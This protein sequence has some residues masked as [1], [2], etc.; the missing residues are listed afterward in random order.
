MLTYWP[1]KI[2]LICKQVMRAGDESNIEDDY[3]NERHVLSSLRCLKHPSI[4]KLVTAYSKGDTYNFL[5]PVADGDLKH[6]LSLEERPLLLES[7]QA[8]FDALWS[9]SSAVES[10]HS[11]F[12]KDFN[13]RQVG[14]HYDIKPGNILYQSE[15]FLLSDFGLSRLRNDSEG[16]RS[17]Y[18]GV[19]GSYIAPECE[20]ASDGFERAKIGRSSDVWSFGCFLFEMLAYLHGGP[21]A[22][23]RLYTGRRVKLGPHWA[24]YFHAGD[25]INPAVTAFLQSF[26]TRNPKNEGFHSLSNIIKAALQIEPEKR[27]NASLMTLSLFHLAQR[28]KFQAICSLLDNRSYLRD[29]ELEMEYQRLK[30]WAEAVGLA[31][32]WHEM[33]NTVWLATPRNH[34]ELERVQDGLKKCHE[35]M[36]SVKDAVENNRPFTNHRYYHLQRSQD[37][38]WDMQPAPVRKSMMSRLEDM[39]LNADDPA[40]LPDSET[41]Q[42]KSQS[43][44]DTEVP[45]SPYRRIILL[46][47]MKQI[48]AAITH[49]K[50]PEKDLM[51]DKGLLSKPFAPYHC[52]F[53]ASLE[54]VERKVLIEKMVYQESWYPR[55]DELLQ[56]VKA[57]TS[58]RDNIQDVIP[59]LESRGYY[60]EP[61][62]HFFG[63]VYELPSLAKD[64]LPMSLHDLIQDTQ[65]RLHQ[66][67]LTMKFDL[68]SKLVDCVLS[69]H[70]AGWLHKNICSFNL[71]CFPGVFSAKAASITDPYMI[72]FNYSRL[73]DK[74]AFTEGPGYELALREYQHPEYLRSSL[75]EYSRHEDS[76]IRYRQ[77]FEYYSVGLVLLEIGLWKPLSRITK[78]L[79]GSPDEMLKRLLKDYIPVVKTHMG[80]FYGE[81][82]KVCLTS[83]SQGIEEPYEA[84][85]VFESGVVSPIR[86]RRI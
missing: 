43:K 33:P 67:S 51:L 41:I 75:G 42:H 1:P 3:N 13:V 11:Y 55:I 62:Q 6:F 86:E 53:V 30:I 80:D 14:C 15:R 12:S 32:E 64:T 82:V 72:G 26:D 81:A 22:V 65:N 39:V 38:L 27:S 66:P 18:K 10:M 69:F 8:I 31:F 74:T 21:K 70:K 2:G 34:E 46:A 61:S 54:G 20:P 56:R 7:D 44:I 40:S 73:N 28:N 17:L 68:A 71:M 58:F 85:R 16:S 52:H 9:L 37:D 25:S 47:M 60:H 83:Y 49:Q 45:R 76:Q 48:G 57:I 29:F 36:K 78:P 84:R 5:F 50:R 63:I 23:S 59:I 77:E 35:E 79:Q 24:H 4:I 19:E